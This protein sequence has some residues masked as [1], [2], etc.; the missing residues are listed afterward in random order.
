MKMN[1]SF[2]VYKNH[3]TIIVNSFFGFDRPIPLPP[4]IHPVGMLEKSSHTELEDEELLEWMRKKNA[5]K[6]EEFIYVAFGSIVKITKSLFLRV[7]EGLSKVGLPVIWAYRSND[8]H[9]T[10]IKDD[11]FFIRNWLPQS[12]ILS[13]PKVKVFVTHGG[14]NSISESVC[15][16]KP[17]AV[18]SFF[19]DQPS[20]AELIQKNKSGIALYVSSNKAPEI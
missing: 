1:T 16:S 4:N 3:A 20:N 12:A 11:N 15:H 19:G 2:I 6:K 5:E 13:H 18:L 8:N 17:M 14:W 10:E 7:Y 9:E